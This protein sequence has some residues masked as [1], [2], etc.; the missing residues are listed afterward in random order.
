MLSADE[1]SK[2]KSMLWRDI[3]PLTFS[4]T[5]FHLFF[6]AELQTVPTGMQNPLE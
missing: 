4:L 1:N 5:Y 2:S 3:E 6:L